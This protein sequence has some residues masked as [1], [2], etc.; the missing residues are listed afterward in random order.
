MDPSEYWKKVGRVAYKLQL[1]EASMI[2]PVFHVSQLKKHLGLNAVPLANLPMVSADGRVK[3][4]PVAVLDRRII[5]R[6]NDVI[7]QWRIQ[8]LNLTPD[9]AT[10][11]DVPFIQKT[12]PDFKP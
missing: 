2:H 6:G 11:E 1:Q 5:P 8:W 10:W 12:F 4:E 9:E 7:A 3:T